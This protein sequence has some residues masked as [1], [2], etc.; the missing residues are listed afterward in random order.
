MKKRMKIKHGELPKEKFIIKDGIPGS[1]R[2]ISTM[3][4]FPNL[5]VLEYLDYEGN[6]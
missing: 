4:V 5:G 1:F 2:L 3:G 6:I